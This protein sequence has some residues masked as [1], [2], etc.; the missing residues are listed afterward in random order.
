MVNSVDEVK[1][2]VFD[3]E[4]FKTVFIS[5][6]VMCVFCLIFI[7]RVVFLLGLV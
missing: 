1:E 7:F 4:I 5:D 6:F 3:V 2:V